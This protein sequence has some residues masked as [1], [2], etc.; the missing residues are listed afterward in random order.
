MQIPDIGP[1]SPHF[2]LRRSTPDRRRNRERRQSFEAAVR[3][4]NERAEDQAD[5]H[6]T[7][8]DP[9]AEPVDLQRRT[10]NVRRDGQ[11]GDRHVDVL[12]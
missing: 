9:A 7:A 4:L 11:D 2:G 1:L 12:A 3:R 5:E 6:Q 8:G 10:P